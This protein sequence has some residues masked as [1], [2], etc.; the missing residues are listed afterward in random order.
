MTAAGSHPL[1]PHHCVGRGHFLGADGQLMDRR[2]ASRPTR[3]A[4]SG[5]SPEAD[6]GIRSRDPS[7]WQINEARF[8]SAPKN[9]LAGLTAR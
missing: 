3:N 9:R 7:P 6:D 8:G 1:N 4:T 5:E 2:T